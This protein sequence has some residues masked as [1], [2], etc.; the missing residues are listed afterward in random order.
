LNNRF[1]YHSSFNRRNEDGHYPAAI[2][3]SGGSL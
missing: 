3:D 2:N 1:E